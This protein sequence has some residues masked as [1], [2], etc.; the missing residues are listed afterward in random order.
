MSCDPGLDEPPPFRTPHVMRTS[1]HSPRIHRVPSG[2]HSQR[3]RGKADHQ[4]KLA[5][6]LEMLSIRAVGT[7]KRGALFKRHP[8]DQIPG[9][10]RA[11]RKPTEC[12]R[13]SK[14]RE[15][16]PNTPGKNSPSRRIVRPSARTLDIF[17]SI[18][19]VFKRHA[20]EPPIMRV[21]RMSAT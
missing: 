9:Q 16:A 5:R 15:M 7:A 10:L 3:Q 2:R 14:N 21:K 6:N 8:V 19:R 20:F 18:R 12:S 1:R 17:C 11:D 4:A 13:A